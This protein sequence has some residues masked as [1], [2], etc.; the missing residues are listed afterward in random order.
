MQPKIISA[1]IQN[2]LSLTHNGNTVIAGNHLEISP[3]ETGKTSTH[4]NNVNKDGWQY[5]RNTGFWTK[6]IRQGVRNCKAFWYL[7]SV[8]VWF[9]EFDIYVVMNDPGSIFFALNYVNGQG[10]NMLRKEQCY[11]ENIAQMHL[12]DCKT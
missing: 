1:Y 10:L 8:Y 3:E 2:I 9:Y 5:R 6:M 7:T 11:D 4:V 12:F